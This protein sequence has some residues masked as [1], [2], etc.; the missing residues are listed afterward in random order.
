MLIPHSFVLHIRVNNGT[1]RAVIWIS[2]DEWKS[3]SNSF[4]LSNKKRTQR[5]LKRCIQRLCLWPSSMWHS[6]LPIRLSHPGSTQWVK[7]VFYFFVMIYQRFPPHQLERYIRNYYHIELVPSSL[8][9]AYGNAQLTHKVIPRNSMTSWPVSIWKVLSR[10]LSKNTVGKATDWRLH[11]ITSSYAKM[12]AVCSIIIFERILFP[13]IYFVGLMKLIWFNVVW[14]YSAR[15]ASEGAAR[16]P[17]RTL[18]EF[19]PRRDASFRLEVNLSSNQAELCS[20]T[21]LA[22]S[23]INDWY[24]QCYHY[25][26]FYTLNIDTL[27]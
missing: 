14:M 11:S 16:W 18:C 15:Q 9:C 13:N 3:L 19:F 6:A 10:K 26:I 5:D 21:R 2:F 25:K 24:S 22:V 17:A 8:E 23:S 7:I 4:E 1:I 20:T 27:N 12:A